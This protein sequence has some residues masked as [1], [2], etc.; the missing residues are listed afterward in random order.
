MNLTICLVFFI[1]IKIFP[2]FW[3]FYHTHNSP[4]PAAVRQIWKE[5]CHIEP[6]T[7]KVQPA[8]DHWTDDVKMTSKMQP[9]QIIEPLTEKTWGRGCVIFGEQKNKK[10]IFYIKSLKIFWI[11]KKAIFEFVFRRIWRIQPAEFFISYESR[12]EFN[13]C[14]IYIFS[15]T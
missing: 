2:R 15:L 8:A 7:S 11:N 6:M 1:I 14:K 9:I 12:I 13:N 4:Y 5:L 3:L 10:L